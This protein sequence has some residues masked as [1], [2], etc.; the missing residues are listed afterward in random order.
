MVRMTPIGLSK[1]K[2]MNGLQCSK[3]LWIQVHQP[4]LVEYGPGAQRI[5]AM[6]HEV[7][8]IAQAL[9]PG[10]AL[11]GP[12][13]DGPLRRGD[14][15]AAED[16]TRRLLS[17]P[18]DRVIYEA[19]FTHN[20]VLVRTDLFFRE[21]GRC[22]FTEVKG[23]T[24]VEK[25]HVQDAAIQAWVLRGSGVPVHEIRL[26]HVDS[27]FVY[28]GNGEYSGLLVEH[29][30]TGKVEALVPQVA[31]Q[32]EALRAML[33][34]KLRDVPVGPQCTNPHECPLY[35]HCRECGDDHH[36]GYLPG[37]KAVHRDLQLEGYA[38]IRD[39]P[40]GRLTAPQ[41]VRVWRATVADEPETDPAIHDR[42][43]S[44]P[45]PRYY[46]DFET[47]NFAAPIWPGSRP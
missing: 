12:E 13:H 16:E 30:I 18:G 33:A 22:R 17:E 11:V 45:Y 23:G 26:A 38:R 19:T 46:F 42:M 41:Q 44:L 4:E 31:G 27:G 34:G 47:I 5:F 24:S 43:R 20:G 39:V 37:R 8:R 14:L 29:D 36:V 3:L 21:A 6:G 35:D 9:H 40:P 10:G 28:E 15:R 7:G 32:V 1:S 2:V 25:Y